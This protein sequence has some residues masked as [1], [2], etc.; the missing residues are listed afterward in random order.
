MA[1]PGG[2]LLPALLG[3]GITMGSALADT[4]DQEQATAM[5][6]RIADAA[7][8]LSFKGTYVYQHG[9]QSET[10]QV[11]HLADGTNEFEKL[12]FLDG[13]RREVI[14]INSEVQYFYPEAKII[15]IENRPRRT[16]PA[17]VLS[18]QIAS[19]TKQ[20]NIRKGESE[21]IAGHDS[22]SLELEPKDGMRYGHK[23]WTEANSGLLLKARMVDERR[24][25]V[26]Q[27]SFT[28]L[29][30]GP[31]DRALL[32]PSF[33]ANSEWR[34]DRFGPPP[35][36]SSTPEWVV[37]LVPSGFRKVL[38]TQTHRTK[39]GNTVTVTHMIFS[40][41]LASVS[42]FIEPTGDREINEGLT[43][44]GAFN[45]YRRTVENQLV[46]VL[47]EAPASAVRQIGESVSQNA[48]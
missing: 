7:R 4:L 38:E 30:I 9:D 33:K 15:R 46:T 28:H 47:G 10:C 3:L 48:R 39:Q 42:V 21:R 29:E 5:L 27:I 24:N 16:F 31:V 36:A 11:F 12:Q 41:G 25:L 13:P 1:R 32:K 20:Y 18:E 14:R 35:S 6:K 26:E 2:V 22:V 40:D 8:Q 17:V 37:K 34:W 44:Q 45:I 43:R 19:I 23:F